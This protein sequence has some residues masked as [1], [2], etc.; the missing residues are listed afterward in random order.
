MTASA[1]ECLL[2]PR[3]CVLANYQ[4]GDC[5]VRVNVDGKLY[6]LVFGKACAA[7][8]KPHREE[9]PF[10][11]PPRHRYLLHRDRRVQPP[12]QVLP[13]LGYQAKPSRRTPT[14]STSRRRRWW[15]KPSAPAAV[16]SPTL[17]PSRTSS[18]NTSSRTS[19]LA[20][21]RGLRNVTVTAAYINEDPLREL[22]RVTDATNADLKA[23]DDKYYARRLRRPA[24]AR[25]CG[26]SSSTR[27]RACGPR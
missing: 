13:E 3:R 23:F 24:R 21:A 1:V 8:V 19:A 10:P 7:H 11:L 14:T 2:C 9:A 16:P 20:R 25:S 5:R 12:L 18:T 4:R 15:T 17:I 26:R 6:S 27:R 22:C